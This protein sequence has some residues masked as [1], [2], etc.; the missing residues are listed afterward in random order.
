MQFV[1]SYL[2]DVNNALHSKFPSAKNKILAYRVNQLDPLTQQSSLTEDCEDDGEAG[3]GGKLLSLLQKMEIE[4]ILVIV[5]VWSAG[6]Q[7]GQQTL[8]GGELFK[9]ITD[10][11]KELLTSI[12]EQIVH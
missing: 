1:K 2:S 5:C 7:I 9:V 8:R 10:R 4:N 3:A 6:A 12:H 11:A